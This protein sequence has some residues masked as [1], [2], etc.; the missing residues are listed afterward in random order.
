MCNAQA[1]T[2]DPHVEENVDAQAL[3]RTDGL[4][5]YRHVGER[6]DREHE[7]VRVANQDEEAHEIFPWIHTVWGNLKRVLGGVHTKASRAQLQDYLD[8]FS[9]R[10]NHRADLA[11]GLGKALRGLVQAGR[12]TREQLKGGAAAKLY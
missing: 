11:E 8:L 12:V 4:T 5:T 10:F 3:V 9:Y 7:L 2:I 1:E 6:T